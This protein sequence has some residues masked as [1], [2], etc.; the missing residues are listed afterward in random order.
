MKRLLVSMTSLILAFTLISA[1]MTES[2]S[3][4]ETF[5][6]M[7]GNVAS[8]GPIPAFGFL[9]SFAKIDA[10]ARVGAVWMTVPI[11]IVP[12]DPGSP[13]IFVLYMAHLI[14]A[15]I[16]KLNFTDN[17]N[18]IHDFLVAGI[19]NVFN[20][21]FIYK[22]STFLWVS[23]PMVDRGPGIFVVDPDPVNGTPWTVFTLAIQDLL[24]VRGPVLFHKI[25][26]VEIPEGDVNLDSKVDICDIVSVAKSFGAMPGRRGFDLQIDLNFDFRIDIIDIV[27]VARAFDKSY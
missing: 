20:V 6:F 16:V 19:W 23:K 10:W 22:E 3:T 14:N 25:K 1:V 27:I 13:V 9:R 7:V 17:M 21:T 11:P 26:T 24:P 15:S 8:Y 2:T 18:R 5:V 4:T 12:G